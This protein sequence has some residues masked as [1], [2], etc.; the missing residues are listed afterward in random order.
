MLLDGEAND[1]LAKE[2]LEA[3]EEW[4]LI[5]LKDETTFRPF[6]FLRMPWVT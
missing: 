3:L 1:A 4:L 5:P 2:L 6:A